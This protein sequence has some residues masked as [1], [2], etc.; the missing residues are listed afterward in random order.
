[1]KLET[2]VRPTTEVFVDRQGFT[3]TCN[4]WANYEG[5]NVMAHSNDL[6]VRAAF[7]LRWEEIDV[8]LVALNAARAA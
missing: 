3:I 5:V 1:M 7:S 8:L 6:A 2:I 4:P